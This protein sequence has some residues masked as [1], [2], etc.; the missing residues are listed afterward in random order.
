MGLIE[1]KQK[2]EQE[3]SIQ[4]IQKK[5][6]KQV[7]D[8]DWKKLQEK[9]Q[10]KYKFKFKTEEEKESAYLPVPGPETGPVPGMG[11]RA[12]SCS[13][14]GVSS[15]GTS[16][17]PPEMTQIL[18]GGVQGDKGA[19][20]MGK[21]KVFDNGSLH[22]KGTCQTTAAY[23]SATAVPPVHCSKGGGKTTGSEPMRTVEIKA[24]DLLPNPGGILPSPSAAAG[25]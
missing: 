25:E 17:G 24:E 18:I 16:S 4:N 10:K 11:T 12:G 23:V 8:E 9:I 22:A 7:Q 15:P 2:Q 6:K 5:K 21:L 20:F 3:S 13:A 14:L 19:S 1:E